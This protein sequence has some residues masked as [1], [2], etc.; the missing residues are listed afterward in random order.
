MLLWNGI[1]QR[2]V[3]LR[4][5]WLVQNQIRKFGGEANVDTNGNQQLPTEAVV[6]VVQYAIKT[7]ANQNND[8]VGVTICVAPPY[9]YH[10]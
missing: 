6:V 3:N 7:S 4:Q 8:N 2:M 10:N 1:P 5:K 9:C